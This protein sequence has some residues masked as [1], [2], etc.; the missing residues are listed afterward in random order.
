MAGYQRPHGTEDVLPTA[1]NK[2]QTHTIKGQIHMKLRLRTVLSLALVVFVFVPSI[3]LAILT[4]DRTI[5][6]V[7]ARDDGNVHIDFADT[8][9]NNKKWGYVG[10]TA[11]ARANVLHVATVALMANRR[12]NVEFHKTGEDCQIDSIQLTQ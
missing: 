2:N 6:K 5:T 4:P 11:E 3:A 7:K 10:G 1:T 12:V 9:C 8:I